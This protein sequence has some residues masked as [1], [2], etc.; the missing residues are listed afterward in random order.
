MI[1]VKPMVRSQVF[2]KKFL[3]Y[4]KKSYSGCNVTI[5][6]KLHAYHICDVLSGDAEFIGAVNTLIFQ[7]NKIIGKNTDI[8]GFL[9]N[10]KQNS[11]YGCAKKTSQATIIGAGGAARSVLYGLT[12]E[13]FN[14]IAV[15]NRTLSTAKQLIIDFQS[16]FPQS[17]LHAVP[18]AQLNACLKQRAEHSL[19]VNTT[20]VGMSGQGQWEV[21][22]TQPFFVTDIIYTPVMTPFL[23]CAAE[24]RLEYQ[25]GFSMLLYQG[26]ESFC[27]WTGLQPKVDF[28]LRQYLLA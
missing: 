17:V 1:F 6:H 8:I 12:Q 9:R 5:P 3:N 25:D 4:K 24:A 23:L 19:V 15:V 18:F 16:E 14:D 27:L 21:Q 22:F 10:I 13:G 2:V 20:S 28:Q 26:A 11:A 7:E